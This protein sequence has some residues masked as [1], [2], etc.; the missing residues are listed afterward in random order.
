MIIDAKNPVWANAENTAINCE[1]Q[2]E[3]YGWIPFTASPLDP[4]PHGVQLW[5]DLNAGKYGAIAPYV[6]PV[7]TAQQNKDRAVQL[8]AATDYTSYPDVGLSTN[9]PYLKNQAEFLA[10]RNK[11]RA[12]AVNPVAG[13]LDWPVK[14]VEVW[15]E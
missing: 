6:A 1:V 5:T 12:I 15:S 13:N 7:P 4:E 8:L 10:F 2:T 14:P 11:V 9:T 3:A